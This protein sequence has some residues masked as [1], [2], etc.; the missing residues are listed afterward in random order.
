MKILICVK[1][2]IISNGAMK[3]MGMKKMQLLVDKA[4]KIYNMKKG[5]IDFE[6]WVKFLV[7][8]ICFLGLINIILLSLLFKI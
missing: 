5:L 4:N 1:C 6:K 8:I 7:G 3:I 2:A